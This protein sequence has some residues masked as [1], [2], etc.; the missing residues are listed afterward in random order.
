MYWI[1]CTSVYFWSYFSHTRD[2]SSPAEAGRRGATRRGKLPRERTVPGPCQSSLRGLWSVLI[3]LDRYL[4]MRA[5]A[6][7]HETQL[8]RDLTSPA[9]STLSLKLSQFGEHDTKTSNLTTKQPNC[10]PGS[11]SK[12]A[13]SR[14]RGVSLP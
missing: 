6:E 11:V 10:L 5:E 2:G 3:R 7:T 13:A 1:L 12:T 4:S 14:L 9:G 8:R